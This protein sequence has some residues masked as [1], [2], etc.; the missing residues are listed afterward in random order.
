MNVVFDRFMIFDSSEGQ[1]EGRERDKYL[2]HWTK[3][4]G[5]NGKVD[6]DEQI[7]DI[8]LCDATIGAS[9]RLSS[10]LDANRI[11]PRD[12]LIDSQNSRELDPGEPSAV[13]LGRHLVL[14]FEST[15]IVMV[16]VEPNNSIWMAVQVLQVQP[17]DIND[18]TSRIG[19]NS[20]LDPESIPT[21]A[22]RQIIGNIYARFCLINGPFQMLKEQA[23]KT[24]NNPNSKEGRLAI[25]ERIR[26]ICDNYFNNVLPDIH[27]SSIISNV[28]PLYNQLTYLDLHPLTLMKVASFINH[29]V[30]INPRQIRHTIAIFNDQLLWSSLNAHD[31]RLVYNYMIGV[32]IRDALQE[33][34]SR[35]TEKV[36]RIKENMPIYLIE[37]NGT[38]E[39]DMSKMDIGDGQ[40]KTLSK[41][42]LTV[43]R[44]SNNMTLGLF[45]KT[46][47][48]FDLIQ[49]CEQIL[50][51]DS[52]LGVVP[53]ASLAKSVGQSFLKSTT[54]SNTSLT[55]QSSQ[56][57]AAPSNPSTSWRRQ[58]AGSSALLKNSIPYDQKYI[59]LDRLESSVSSSFS[60]DTPTRDHHPALD[61]YNET[62]SSS[63][64]RRL[65]K[66][67]IDLEPEMMDIQK[68]M[69]QRFEEYLVKTNAD[70][71]I[72][73]MNSKYR[74]IY[75]VYR[76]RNAGLNEAQL[77]ANNLKTALVNCRPLFL[78]SQ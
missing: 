11:E 71:W 66:F 72:T 34:L 24:E 40:C 36:R 15:V 6:I 48:Q 27:L 39:G 38:L 52:R 22:I 26:A 41:F 32:L 61:G 28:A 42:Y 33:E 63:R 29:L 46:I 54:L 13:Q 30:C 67:M 14:M 73:V 56:H 65:V 53:L 49:R 7:D 44:S 76:M 45:F 10:G 43:F 35:E 57:S 12:T 17:M 55:P 59:C 3:D 69:G 2:Y 21:N 70:N 16:E 78:S 5:N 47:D 20:T 51:S 77:A 8:C 4:A 19:H 9:T 25:K 31:S 58:S 74:C 64:K 62:L 18:S 75:S 60:M 50:T 37:S 23:T 68:I 1:D